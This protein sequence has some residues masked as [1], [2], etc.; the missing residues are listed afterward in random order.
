MPKKIRWGL[1]STA[2]INRRL[3]PAIKSS[4]RSELSAVASRNAS[5][6]YDYAKLW[7]IPRT[8]DSYEAMLA[9]PDIDAVYI[10]LPNHLHA[11]WSIRALHAGK[12]VLCEKPF[13]LS[14]AEVDRMIQASLSTGCVIAEAFMYRHHP[15]TKTVLEWVNSDRLGKIRDIFGVF[16]F[17]HPGGEDFRLNPTQG[18]G[19][20]WDVG[21][22]PVSFAQAVY[23][24]A[25][26]KSHRYIHPRANRD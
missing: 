9:S 10:S 22:Y 8:F 11:E 4:G 1:L 2:K 3:I 5:T 25:P 17:K 18:G 21:V 19:S 13:A 6:A 12:N 16:S 7:G 14:V 20:L 26:N 23:G 15:Q 24:T